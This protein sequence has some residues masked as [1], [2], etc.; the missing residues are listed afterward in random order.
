[1]MQPAVPLQQSSSVSK[2]DH[3][4]EMALDFKFVE[5]AVISY[6]NYADKRMERFIA[7]NK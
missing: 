2:A 3:R 5:S 6:E 7:N 4:T 1:M